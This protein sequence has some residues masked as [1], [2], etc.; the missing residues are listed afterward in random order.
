LTR[1]IITVLVLSGLLKVSLAIVFADLTPRYDEA[2]FL[3][4]A[5]AIL[6][7]AQPVLW[8]A[9][10]YQSF[11]AAGLGLGG[12]SAV[13]ARV[14]Q[15]FL[16]VGTTWVVWTIGRRV[17]PARAALAAAAFVA[18]Y[19]PLVAFSHLL[20]AETLY[21]AVATVAFE[22]LLA[23]REEGGIRAAVFAGAAL[24]AACLVRSSGLVLLAASAAWAL[25]GEGRRGRGVAAALV[26]TAAL[27]VAPWSLAATARAGRLVIIDTNSGYNLWSGNNR[28]IPGDLQGIWAVGLPLAN[29]VDAAIDR[30]LRS[31]GV[32]ASPDAVTPEAGWRR[33]LRDDLAAAGIHDLATPATDEWFRREAV[34]EIWADPGEFVRR[35]PRRVAA[36]WAPDFFLARHLARDWYG[37]LPA[38]A[39]SVLVL[40]TVLASA[41]PLVLGPAALASLRASAFRSLT[42]SWVLATLLAHA[43]TF[44]VSRMHEP[45]SPMLAIAAAGWVFRD[46]A[47]GGPLRPAGIAAAALALVAWIIAAPV[48]A[49][50]YVAPGPR[51]ADLARAIGAAR[52]LP[53][54]GT[55]WAGWMVAGVEL[56]AGE[57][58]A[59]NRVLAE[60]RLAQEPWSLYLRA[61]A[62]EDRGEALRF[63]ERAIARDPDFAAASRLRDALAAG[64]VP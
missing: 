62:T 18:F 36:L 14:L 63:A 50:L 6:A 12:G 41:I 10:G 40:V 37:E 33:E 53:L 8:R 15:A 28:F 32:V 23:A 11:L 43:V 5:R 48:V 46:R 47:Q 13:G 17:F 44:G 20:W 26:G 64:A 60:P 34:A 55:R 56:A 2:E 25:A 54:E 51:H 22:R 31:R 58:G 1:G 19:P 61:I 49:G 35:V 24:G 30:E 21:I 16:S 9:P 45:L 38:G 7:G 42:F 59:A 4:F 29:G 27:I 3:D 57:R 39:V 52:H